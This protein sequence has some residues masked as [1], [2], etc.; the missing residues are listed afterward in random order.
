MASAK[1]LIDEAIDLSD[2]GK[3]R[4]AHKLLTKAIKTD[5]SNPQAYF[6]RAIVLMNLDRDKDALPDLEQCLQLDPAYLGARDWHAKALAG[7]GSLQMAA[8]E[9]LRSLREHPDGELGMSVSPQ[10]WADCTAA[11]ANVG[12]TKKAVALLEEYLQQH[13]KKVSAYVRAETAPLRMLSR[14]LLETGQP[15]RAVK[16][17]RSA[18][19]NVKHR[20]PMDF[21]VCALALEAA[22]SEKEALKV[23]CEALQQNDQMEEAIALKRRLLA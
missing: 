2:A 14:L 23:A 11:F 4:Q 13:A 1:E 20:C 16:L 8:E 3:Y 17:A 19:S 12:E 7:A 21:V 9:M 5:S 18:Y 10:K 6:E 22:G 15:E